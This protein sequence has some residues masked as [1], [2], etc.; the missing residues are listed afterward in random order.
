MPL[1]RLLAISCR[2]MRHYGLTLLSE[3]KWISGMP[4]DSTSGLNRDSPDKVVAMYLVWPVPKPSIEILR[5]LMTPTSSC[6]QTPVEREAYYDYP[7][8]LLRT[9]T[10]SSQMPNYCSI[11]LSSRIVLVS[12]RIRFGLRRTICSMDGSWKVFAGVLLTMRRAG[13]M[14][15]AV[16]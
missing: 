12:L 6:H 14:R 2:H 4:P 10:G 7:T 3:S 15:L 8:W 11:H 16:S 5:D 9:I 13:L 1:A